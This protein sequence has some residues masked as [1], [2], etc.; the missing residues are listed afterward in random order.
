MTPVRG[1]A[2]ARGALEAALASGTLHHAW[3][4]AGP[5]GVGKA[6]FAR[7][8]AVRLLA[9]HACAD[10]MTAQQVA[11]GSHPRLRVLERLP[12]D[13]EKPE[14]GQRRNISVD[15]VR[16]LQTLLART[17]E[18]GERR[19]IVI[20][21]A[22]DL[23]APAANALLKNL[24]EPPAGAV[25]LLVSHAPGRLLPTIRSRCRVLRFAALDDADMAAALRAATPDASE[26]DLAAMLR[27]GAGAPGRALRFAGLDLAAIE[28]DLE[29][30][31]EK[32]DPDNSVRSRLAKAMAAKTA[33]PRFAAFV[34]RVPS[35]IAAHAASRSGERLRSALDAYAAAR[36]AGGAALRLSQDAGTATF[37]LATIVTR[38][39]R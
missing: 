3:L 22:D 20:D 29:S 16:G 39:A 36:E 14:Q 30:L 21:S 26:A 18:P 5:E 24:E 6:S 13:P 1:N 28:A 2:A 8:V 7:E 25:F 38:L 9:D 10:E 33:Q 34:E 12:K 35:F 15:Q 27:A 23:E 4:L 17:V 31:A 37:E 11:A 19:V 32:G